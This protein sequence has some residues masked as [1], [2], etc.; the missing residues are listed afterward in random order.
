VAIVPEAQEAIA[1]LAERSQPTALI[2]AALSRAVRGYS[3]RLHPARGAV[4]AF[5]N[6]P[7]R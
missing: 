5:G 3:A 6:L 1:V 2:G 4:S 7:G